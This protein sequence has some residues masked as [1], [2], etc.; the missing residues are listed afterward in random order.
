MKIALLTFRYPH[1]PDRG[2]RITALGLLKVASPKHRFH[3]LAQCQHAPAPASERYM[4]D[5]GV[6]MRTVRLARERSTVQMV[7]ALPGRD[8]FQL[9]YFRSRAFEAA[10]QDLDA[11]GPFDCVIAHAVRMLPA[12]RL[13]RARRRILLAVD[14]LS[15]AMRR[16]AECSRGPVRWLAAEEAKRLAR[17]EAL[18]AEWADEVWLISDVDAAEFPTPL[19]HKVRVVRQGIN[20]GLDP[21]LG[22]QPDGRTLLFVGRLDV[23][24]N[25]AAV[26]RLCREILPRVR[27][28]APR[29]RVRIVGASP[30]PAVKALAFIPG[31]EVAGRVEDLQQEYVRAAAM[32]VPLTF[33]SGM[34]NKILEAAAAGLP[35]V[36]TTNGAAG[37][38]PT[39]GARVTVADSSDAMARAALRILAHPG[40]F[41]AL[42]GR[43]KQAAWEGFRW[44]NFLDALNRPMAVPSGGN[45]PGAVER[46]GPA[47]GG[48]PA[49]V[50]LPSGRTSPITR[51]S[52][53]KPSIE[54]G[55]LSSSG[56]R[57]DT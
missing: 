52:T 22:W 39:L 46:W 3:V 11:R 27:R 12:A 38:G 32:V 16:M 51:T 28:E 15:M 7:L 33:S 30:A 26:Q 42:A 44:E 8:S 2:D 31:V 21:R 1:P 29:A 14:C 25:I 34:Q 24:H 41:L 53:A 19:R 49:E 54:S 48:A 55:T 45:P 23:R 9:A 37:L 47:T 6:D 36:T 13:V 10:A 57:R 56:V 50:Y 18:G 43:A 40:E 5:L 35:V 20:V 17:A 4:R